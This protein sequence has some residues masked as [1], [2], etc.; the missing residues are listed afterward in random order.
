MTF[1]TP[2]P[3][4]AYRNVVFANA[5]RTMAY[6]NSTLPYGASGVFTSAKTF[7]CGVLYREIGG[8]QFFHPKSDPAPWYAGDFP[9]SADFLGFVIEEVDGLGGVGVRSINP[10]LGGIEG[11]QLGPQQQGARELVVKG[12]L[13]ATSTAGNEYGL[14][15]LTNLLSAGDCDLCATAP[16]IV[17]TACPPEDASNEQLGRYLIYDV[18]LTDG[19]HPTAQPIIDESCD[20]RAIEFTL[21]AQNPYLYGPVTEIM[22]ATLLPFVS[23]PGCDLY[24]PCTWLFGPPQTPI[25]SSQFF[26]PSLGTLGVI[27]TVTSPDG[28]G[29]LTL[30]LYETCPPTDHQSG[31][32]NTTLPYSS[33]CAIAPVATVGAGGPAIAVGTCHPLGIGGT[34]NYWEPVLIT[35]PSGYHPNRELWWREN[36]A[37]NSSSPGF[38]G[39]F[40]TDLV[41]DHKDGTYS[42]FNPDGWSGRSVIETSFTM[43]SPKIE[44]YF[45]DVATPFMEVDIG[46]IP[47]GGILV[48]DS[49]RREIT[50]TAPDP[51]TGLTV[52]T[53]GSPLLD[54]PAGEL[55]DWLEVAACTDPAH[56]GRFCICARA[57]HPCSTREMSS[58]TTVEIQTQLRRK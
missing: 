26:A 50:L 40:T 21:T 45:F 57:A 54:I 22:A 56:P 4:M 43:S 15:W 10:R 8:S 33:T 2:L 3:W 36:P 17:R 37:G 1:P 52:V 32:S 27:I 34:F 9:E 49:A 53:D 48:I 28:L 11:A 19:P 23:D 20:I 58:Q 25:C 16:L 41:V 6:I 12:C 5:A 13:V 47:S 31:T 18:G 7:P 14:R 39:H 55:L 38:N 35:D 44:A 46:N 42:L 51:T 24:G 30:G 29:G